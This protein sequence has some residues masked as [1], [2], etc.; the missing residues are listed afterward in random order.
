MFVGIYCDN[1]HELA[2]TENLL[3]I[4]LRHGKSAGAKKIT[5]LYL[6]IGPLSSII[7]ES[8]QFYWDIIAKE[9]IA[10]GAKLHF[11]RT[12][13][14]FMCLD[15]NQE[16]LLNEGNFFCP[17]CGSI[18]RKILSGDEFYLECIDIEA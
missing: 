9:T 16:F 13:C 14:K 7:D 18:N 1:M 6:V 12:Q 11:K 10:E 2:A 5:D 17:Y 8:V 3:D 4:A 15:C